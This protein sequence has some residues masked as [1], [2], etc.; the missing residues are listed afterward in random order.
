MRTG[1]SSRVRVGVACPIPAERA[2]FLEWLEGAHY[3][4]V[5]LLD[6]ASIVNSLETR[7]FEVLVADVKIFKKDDLPFI[8]RLLGPNRPLI[9][10]GDKGT[11]A[12]S[13]PRE[14]SWLD[15][16]VAQD[17]LLLSVALAL[18]EGR[19][20]RRSPRR[21]VT[22]LLSSIDGITS[23]VLD[24][25]Q[26]GVRLEVTGTTSSAL[27]PMFTMRVPAFGV[28]TTV[29]RVWVAQPGR[30]AVWCGG[31]VMRASPKAAFAWKTLLENAPTTGE[32][33]HEG[34]RNFN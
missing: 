17:A 28:V 14:A 15:R 13:I 9:L 33:F 25:S 23:S 30:R 20:A 11:P 34:V 5:G 10:V 22:N 3:E 31:T 18:A 16:G 2:A 7:P 8:T 26:E 6:L 27:P 4:A 29:K 19:P 12:A 24:V 32:V 1:M 21:P